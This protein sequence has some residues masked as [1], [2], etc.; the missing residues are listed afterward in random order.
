MSR[1][2]VTEDS[3]VKP[4]ATCP[5]EWQIT[6]R[7]RLKG[8]RRKGCQQ[9]QLAALMLKQTQLQSPMTAPSLPT[10]IR[11]EELYLRLIEFRY[12]SNTFH[13]YVELDPLRLRRFCS[14]HLPVARIRF[15][16]M[17]WGLEFCPAAN[18][19]LFDQSCVGIRALVMPDQLP[20][21]PVSPPLRR[22]C[23]LSVG[24]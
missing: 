1:G 16:W 17:I 9:G 5:S 12:A 24:L 10:A 3:N 8:H 20:I 14:A 23:F 11:P 21:S 18:R 6:A 2:C 4:S 15:L 19:L 22:G 13:K 7:L